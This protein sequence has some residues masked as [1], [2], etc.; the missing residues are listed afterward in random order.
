MALVAV[1]LI[2]MLIEQERMTF[3]IHCSSCNGSNRTISFGVRFQKLTMLMYRELAW[4]GAL[5]V[6]LPVPLPNQPLAKPDPGLGDYGG[7]VASRLRLA[8]LCMG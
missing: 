3:A 1:A 4:T 2:G 6:P 5:P 8:N 7:S